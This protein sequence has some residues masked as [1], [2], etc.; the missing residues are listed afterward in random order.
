MCGKVTYFTMSL[1]HGGFNITVQLER[2][3]NKMHVNEMPRGF[4]VVAKEVNS[5]KVLHD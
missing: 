3:V 2:R 5:N 4:F 1:T